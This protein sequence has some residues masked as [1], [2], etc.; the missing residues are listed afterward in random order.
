MPRSR[1]SPGKHSPCKPVLDLETALMN[2]PEKRILKPIIEFLILVGFGLTAVVEGL[3]LEHINRPRGVYD[4]I[5]AGN[6]LFGIGVALLIVACAYA[7]SEMRRSRSQP[8]AARR[9]EGADAQPKTKAMIL[10]VALTALNIFLIPILGYLVPAMIFFILNFTLFKLTKSQG[11]N[12]LLGGCVGVAFFL[13]FQHALGM[14]FPP[15]LF[16]LDFGIK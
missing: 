2:L 4:R 16:G 10:T 13:L 15:G 11:L 7:V 5:G 6:F 14:F 12:V 8:N 1:P 9:P 3:R